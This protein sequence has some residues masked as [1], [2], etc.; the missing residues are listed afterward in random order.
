MDLEELWNRKAEE[1]ESGGFDR[2]ARGDWMAHETL[3]LGKMTGVDQALVD[4]ITF[5]VP[6]GRVPDHRPG[7]LPLRCPYPP[8]GGPLRQFV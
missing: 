3:D 7:F 5:V 6:G 1:N 8:L 2:N 4:G